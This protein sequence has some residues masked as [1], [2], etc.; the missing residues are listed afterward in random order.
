MN[1]CRY[2][3]VGLM[4]L[5]ISGCGHTVKESLKQPL[6][7]KST[8]G[9]ERTIVILPFAD[10]SAADD[11]ESA[12]RR[13]LIINE[14]V[15]DQLVAN[16]FNLPVQEDVF[17]YLVDN[18]IIDPV[19]YDGGKSTIEY[20]LDRG[21][22][23]N[24]MRAEVNKHLASSGRQNLKTNMASNSSGTRGLTGQEIVKIGRH[25]G[26]DYVL[27]GRVV[28][29]TGRE[30]PSWA[31]WK[32]GLVNFAYGVESRFYLGQIRPVKYDN[33]GDVTNDK[34]S[35]LSIFNTGRSPQAV[36]QLRIW[37]QN[38]YTGEVVWTNRADIRV[39][40]VSFFADYQY[41]DLFESATEKAVDTLISNFVNNQ[42][43]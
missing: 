11:I 34:L 35:I 24:S 27:R 41:D 14:N 19:V 18:N 20:E 28:K 7:K 32:I 42:M 29:Y 17:M 4:V 23:S 12:Y 36:V 40:P 22:W 33:W 16:G 8:V 3:L 39:S 31:P 38:A 1:Y 30:D 26:A 13:N 10:Y 2:L 37:I 6:V 25:F 15:V 21:G 5:V 9:V 43:L